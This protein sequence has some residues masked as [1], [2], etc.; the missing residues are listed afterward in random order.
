MASYIVVVIIVLLFSSNKSLIIGKQRAL[1]LEV[2]CNF[3]LYLKIG[4]TNVQFS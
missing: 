4:Q 2:T 3:R 1:N